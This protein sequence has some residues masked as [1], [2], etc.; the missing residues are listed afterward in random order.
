MIVIVDYGMGNLHSVS[1]AL[2]RM[3]YE[4]AITSDRETIL[5]ADAIILPGVGAFGKAM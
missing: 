2:E 4:S 3:G 1:K 5:Q